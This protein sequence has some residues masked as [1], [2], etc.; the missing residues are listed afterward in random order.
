MER[1]EWERLVQ[2]SAT[3]KLSP[4]QMQAAI[5]RADQ[6]I[7]FVRQQVRYGRSTQNWQ[8]PALDNIQRLL[9]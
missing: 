1:E 6:V 7:Q 5:E 3:G 8:R 4:E 2:A 9:G